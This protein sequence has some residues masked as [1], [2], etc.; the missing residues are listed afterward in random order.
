[1]NAELRDNF[2]DFQWFSERFFSIRDAHSKIIPFKM[3]ELQQEL[4]DNLMGADDILKARKGGV[5]TYI[6]LRMLHYCLTHENRRGFILAHEHESSKTLLGIARTAWEHLP[7]QLKPALDVD[8]TKELKFRGLTSGIRCHTARNVD[9]G[10]GDTIDFLH[11]SEIAFWDEPDTTMTSIAAALGEDPEVFRESTA[12]GAGNYWH[13]EWLQGKQGKSGYKTHFFPWWIDTKYRRDKA[14]AV[15]D[16]MEFTDAG[17][18]KQLV[19][20]VKEQS[21]PIDDA[22]IRWRRRNI[23][24]FKSR[25]PQEYAEN[26]IECFLTSGNMVFDG[27]KMKALLELL[28]LRGESN[29][30]EEDEAIGLK[31]YWKPADKK[32]RMAVEYVI[33][34][35]T[36]EGLADEDQPGMP[37]DFCS[38][39]IIERRTGIQAASVYGSWEP[40]EFA[41]ILNKVAYHFSSAHAGLP[42]LGVER[43]EYGH[44]TLNQLR[45]HIGYSNIYH[46]FAYDKVR[47]SHIRKPGWRTSQ[48]TRPI[49]ITDL[50]RAVDKGWMQVNDPGLVAECLTFVR[51]KKGRPEAQKGC[52][53][54]RVMSAAIA[55]QMYQHVGDSVPLTAINFS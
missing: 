51:N 37:G 23:T 13:Q 45:N 32:Q 9:I 31:I 16:P 50:V 34:A 27:L 25:F 6:I 41:E 17:E 44:A 40:D 21:L 8:N 47:Q 5:S 1:M 26:D 15:R 28:I 55:W 20:T 36:S 53:D 48:Q 54:D 42:L 11:C 7:D 19:P 18:Q 10:R 38:A 30:I 49:M 4:H 46:E 22:Q 29:V 2:Q 35:D 43:N 52:H 3:N 12:N 24:R 39:S 33:G 14:D